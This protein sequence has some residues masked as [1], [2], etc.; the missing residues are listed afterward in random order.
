MSGEKEKKFQV[1]GETVV[2]DTKSERVEKTPGLLVSFA[3]P[4][5]PYLFK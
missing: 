2:G 1:S 5:C 3:V 4:L